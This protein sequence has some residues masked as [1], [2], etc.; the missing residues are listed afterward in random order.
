MSDTKQCF[1]CGEV[2]SLIDFYKHN[3]M[4]DGHLGKCKACARV[5]SQK[6]LEKKQQD[7]KWVAKER[8]RTRL[9]QLKKRRTVIGKIQTKAHNSIRKMREE[10]D[11]KEIELHHWSYCEEHHTDIIELT[12]EQHRK[13]HRY[14]KLDIDQLMFRTTAGVLMDTKQRALIEYDR[15]LTREGD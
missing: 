9:H 2:K 10:I 1:K 14:I 5:D 12:H 8:E 4:S 6:Q 3:Q 13:I 11:S 15:I 7:P